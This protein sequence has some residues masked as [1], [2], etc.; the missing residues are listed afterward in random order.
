MLTHHARPGGYTVGD[1]ERYVEAWSQTGALTAM[2]N[3]YRAVVRHPPAGSRLGPI[4]APTL[5][6][7]GERD[8]HLGAELAEPSRRDVPGLERVVRLPQASHWVAVDAADEVSRLLVEFFS[9]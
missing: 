9:E 6:I 4:E 3:Y 5:V 7:W 2:L 1:I 8:R